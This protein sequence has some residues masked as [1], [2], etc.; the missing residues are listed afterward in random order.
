ALEPT[1]AVITGAY[2][3]VRE[4]VASPW[5]AV[6]VALAWAGT[7]LGRLVLDRHWVSDSLGGYLAGVALGTACAGAYE[8]ARDG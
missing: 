4:G 3:L 6:P 2:V 7:A 8:L 1:A 5:V